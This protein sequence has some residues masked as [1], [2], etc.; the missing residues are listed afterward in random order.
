ML[1]RGLLV[2]MMIAAVAVPTFSEE[3]SEPE[4]AAIVAGP[5]SCW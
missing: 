5:S 2:M 3:K 4:T 1:P